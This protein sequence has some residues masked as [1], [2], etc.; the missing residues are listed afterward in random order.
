MNTNTSFYAKPIPV[1]TLQLRELDH[2]KHEIARLG[3]SV[4]LLLKKVET[5]Q[6]L[7]FSDVADLVRSSMRITSLLGS[8]VK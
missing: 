6:Q 8:V 5:D 3:S 7:A 4:T 2:L 1:K